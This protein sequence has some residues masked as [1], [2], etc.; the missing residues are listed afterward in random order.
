MSP[1]VVGVR[2]ETH[3]GRGDEIC[4]HVIVRH[5]HAHLRVGFRAGEDAGRIK[6]A[7]ILA[8]AVPHDVVG[9]QNIRRLGTHFGAVPPRFPC[10]WRDRRLTNARV[11]TSAGACDAQACRYSC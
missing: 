11:R 4:V 10:H 9:D 2:V 8:V 6:G 7:L 5:R 3:L 1:D